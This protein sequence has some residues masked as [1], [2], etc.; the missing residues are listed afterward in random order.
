MQ[1]S[2][3]LAVAPKAAARSRCGC[4][5]GKGRSFPYAY[6]AP[7]YRSWLEEALPQLK[8]LAPDLPEEVRERDVS[9]TVEVAVQKPKT[10]KKVRPAG[11]NDNYEKGL[12]D[13]MTKI[14]A[15][16]KDDDQ[17]VVNQTSKRWAYP[18]EEPGYRVTVRFLEP[19]ESE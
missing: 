3:T 6:T 19:Q 1:H 8:K 2:F 4:R 13:A 15:W 14:G 12:W 7:P 9:I 11:D 10:T 16:W 17:I 5:G 18:G